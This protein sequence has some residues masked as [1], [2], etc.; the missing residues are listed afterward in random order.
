MTKEQLKQAQELNKEYDEAK[1]K[2]G[3]CNNIDPSSDP[4]YEPAGPLWKSSLAGLT[5][6]ERLIV[7]TIIHAMLTA[8]FNA[9]EKAMNEYHA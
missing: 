4:N 9:A 7:K 5:K 1:Q 2:L 6:Q 3:Y 8:R